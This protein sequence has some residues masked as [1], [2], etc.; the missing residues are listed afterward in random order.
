MKIGRHISIALAVLSLAHPDA[1]GQDARARARRQLALRAAATEAV[2]TVQLLAEADADVDATL[3]SMLSDAMLRDVADYREADASRRQ[4]RPEA[5][6]FKRDIIS[7]KV[8]D[9]VSRA[10]SHSPKE[11]GIDDLMATLGSD[12]AARRDAAVAEYLERG[13]EQIFTAARR[14]AVALQREQL[15][16]K[17]SYPEFDTLDELLSETLAARGQPE[18]PLGED[19]FKSL[20]ARL[21]GL[22]MDDLPVFEEV[23]GTLRELNDSVVNHIAE[24]YGRQISIVDE[25]PAYL[26]EVDITVERIVA[27]IGE[28]LAH[29]VRPKPGPPPA[30]DIFS[31]TRI[32]ADEESQALESSLFAQFIADT[33]AIAV[34]PGAIEDII[35]DDLAGHYAHGQ[36][37]DLLAEHFSG[38][39]APEL[40]SAYASAKNAELAAEKLSE[41][42]SQLTESASLAAA[43]EQRI[44]REIDALL[45]ALRSELARRQVQERLPEVFQ[46]WP[47]DTDV[48]EWLYERQSTSAAD[49]DQLAEL[50]ALVGAEDVDIAAMEL[51]EESEKLALEEFNSRA[52]P[53]AAAL[54]AQ[55]RVVAEVERRMLPDLRQLIVE[56][57]RLRQ[58]LRQWRDLWRELWPDKAEAAE[59]SQMMR[60]ADSQLEKNVRQRYDSIKEE[61]E[62]EREMVAKVDAGVAEPSE[63]ADAVEESDII[64][65]VDQEDDTDDEQLVGETLPAGMS[66]GFGEMMEGLAGRADLIFRFSD[67]VDGRA[68]FE[69]ASPNIA[70]GSRIEFDST[71]VDHASDEISAAVNDLLVKV[72]G[73]KAEQ[74]SGIL[75]IP[76][77][78]GRREPVLSIYVSVESRNLRH[79]TIVGLRQSLRNDLDTLSAER[80]LSRFEIQWREW[81]RPDLPQ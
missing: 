76:F 18:H 77:M 33:D 78:T 47:P 56:G 5:E 38:K 79:I 25:T 39:F 3:K 11:I 73:S 43:Y 50:L 13:Y 81:Q 27:V 10:Q 20:G 66:P 21:E 59:F 29:G 22:I 61:I 68:V 70:S 34:A 65:V 53:A 51:I 45:P 32:Y 63:E 54:A 71:R 44:R 6:R 2:E 35:A 46:D 16:Q 40:A 28:R 12:W 57:V 64:E 30:Y 36:S 58:I 9:I 74:Q 23:E 31:V 75:R 49:M 8:A 80:D 7:G 52:A 37:A 48:A 19:D 24:E 42:S 17:V 67:G 26:D 55:M 69:F 72:A 1:S 62:L 4:C 14:T 15:A 41:L 60:L